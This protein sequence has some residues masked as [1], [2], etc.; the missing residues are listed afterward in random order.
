[1]M[2]WVLP[3]GIADLLPGEAAT[4]ESLRRRLLD[5]CR[6]F[7]FELV[8]P[9]LIEYLDSLLIGSGG[10]LNLKTFK[11]VDQ[12]TGRTLGVRADMTPQIAVWSLPVAFG[13]SV[14]TGLVFGVY[15]AQAAAKLD[16]IEA[17]RHT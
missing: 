15:P 17:L 10:D 5:R 4:L 2:R 16:P 6:A 13:F 1:M 14:L 7:G 8:Q 9:P 12:L 3:E 11:L